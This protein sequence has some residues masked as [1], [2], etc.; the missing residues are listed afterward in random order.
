MTINELIS[1][2]IPALS[3]GSS[4]SY[5]M[6]Q[7]DELHLSELP[8][9]IDGVFLGLLKESYLLELYDDVKDISE[10]VLSCQGCY[11]SY[12]QHVLDA[13]KV[14]DEHSS[15]IVAVLD[16]ANKFVGCISVKDIAIRLGQE[17]FIQAEGGTLVLSLQE[18]DYSLTEIAR[19][20]E[21]NGAKIVHA[22]ASYD[23]LDAMKIRL[24]LKINQTDIGRI[25]ATLER[26]NYQIIERYG[27][28]NVPDLDQERLGSLLRYLSI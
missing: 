10:L 17:Y 2:S 1:L 5:A 21:S 27:S 20:I 8:V 6:M 14:A 19:L 7:M 28:S 4:A 23:P 3:K 12:T 11:I 26:F 22:F 9:V 16:E 15:S 25:V 18:R 13:L 24:T